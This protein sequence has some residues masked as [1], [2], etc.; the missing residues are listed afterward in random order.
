MSSSHLLLSCHLIGCRLIAYLIFISSHLYIFVSLFISSFITCQPF[1]FLMSFH[2]FHLIL[3]LHSPS[4]I[5]VSNLL[6]DLLISSYLALTF[7]SLTCLFPLVFFFVVSFYILVTLHPVSP[8][9]SECRLISRLISL[10][11]SVYFV[12]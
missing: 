3:H 4:H 5:S 12:V 10:H 9:F 7:L 11:V 1:Y 2:V 6:S 8:H